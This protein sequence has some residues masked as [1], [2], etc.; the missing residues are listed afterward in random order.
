[1]K[2][3]IKEV[4]IYL[5]KSRDESDGKEDVLAK[6]ESLLLEY[7]KNHNLKYKIYK[8]IGSSEY[9]DSRPKMVRLLSDVSQKLYDAVLVVDLDRLSRGDLEEMGRISRVFRDS[10]TIV[11][12]PT[13]TYDFNNEEQALIN[14]FEMVFANHEFRMIRKRMI[15]GKQQGTKAG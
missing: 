15:R 10:K 9:I 7:A 1:M 6:H 12:T 13:K 8:E 14:N 2:P 3:N 11:I 4:A 5:R